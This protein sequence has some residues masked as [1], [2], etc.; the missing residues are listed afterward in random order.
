MAKQYQYGDTVVDSMGR[1]GIAKFD[2]KTGK[3]LKP[4]SPKINANEIGQVSPYRL[5]PQVTS[6]ASTGLMGTIEA[7]NQQ[8]RANIEPLIDRNAIEQ[9]IQTKQSLTQQFADWFK[10]RSGQT[11]LT[12]QAYSGTVD[13]AKQELTD[14]TNQIN[15]KQLAY[16]RQIEK[17]QKNEEGMFGGAVGQEVN[18]IERQAAQELADLSII[19]QAKQNNYANAKEIADRKVAL[20]LENDKNYFEALSFFY[21]ENKEELNKKEQQQFQ[22]LI[23]ER[24]RLLEEQ[25]TNKKAI[26]D[27]AMEALR[28]GA[29]QVTAQKILNAQTQEEALALGGRFMGLEDR[30]NNASLRGQRSGIGG[31][32][33]GGGEYGNDLDAIIGTVLSTIPTKFGQQTFNQQIANARNDADRINLIA[34]Q[35]LKGQPAEFKN[36]FRNQAVGIAQLDKAIAALDS[37]VK[38]GVLQNTAQYAANFLGKDFDP[39][40][41]EI[42]GYIT[43]AIQPYRN[44]VTGA[45][46]GD[47]EDA[48]YQQLFGSTKYSP[49]E[50]RQRLLQTKEL[51]KSKSAEG[52]NAYVNPLGYYGNTFETGNLTPEINNATSQST[53]PISGSEPGFWGK[54]G[55]WLFGDN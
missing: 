24:G 42:S 31:G 48:E 5:A 45:A 11:A 12:D 22:L 49:T 53:Q 16:R 8:A 44:S 23:D 4:I 28:N 37:G 30:L 54:V 21:N 19:Q 13:P 32:G 26:N 47:Q 52:L 27:I 33:M 35:V 40:L 51:L 50:L 17:I 2:S 10:N 46:W 18:R 6:S 36:D 29:D 55:S 7:T 1:T 3:T 20:Q 43:S 41:A 39:K 38:T 34:A 15:A 9:G 25:T 14:I